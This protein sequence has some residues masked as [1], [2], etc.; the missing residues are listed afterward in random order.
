MECMNKC[1]KELTGRQRRFCSDKCRMAQARTK[2]D[3][4]EAAQGPNPN[5]LVVNNP[6]KA[7]QIKPEQPK[8]NKPEQAVRPANFGLSDCDCRM[9]RSNRNNGYK[10]TI[11]HGAYKPAPELAEHELN[12]VSLPGDADYTGIVSMLTACL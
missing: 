11:N 9:C 1:G 10:H 12:R 2:S 5:T 4:Q 8:S 7:E 6:N 3:A